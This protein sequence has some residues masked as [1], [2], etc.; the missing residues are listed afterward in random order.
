MYIF[1]I[2][3]ANIGKILKNQPIGLLLFA[4]IYETS[5][6]VHPRGEQKTDSQHLTKTSCRTRGAGGS[7]ISLIANRLGATKIT[8]AHVASHAAPINRKNHKAE[9]RQKKGEVKGGNRPVNQSPTRNPGPKINNPRLQRREE[10]AA[11][12][13]HDEAG[14]ANLDVF[15]SDALERHAVDCRGHQRHAR[16]HSHEA[17]QAR[18]TADKNHNQQKP[19]RRNR[20]RRKELARIHETKEEGTYEPA[21]TEQAH[22]HHI[23]LLRKYLR[24]LLAH[25]L[26]HEHIVTGIN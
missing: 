12:D 21:R 17:A 11:E 9:E 7:Y 16:R 1:R 22:R 24:R 13:G 20:Q 15:A 26:A 18:M 10:G 8:R 4:N 6:I 25:T 2:S 3:G 5:D 23:V 14:G 19:D